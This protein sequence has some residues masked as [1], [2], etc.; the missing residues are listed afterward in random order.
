[1]ANTFITSDMVAP[2]ILMRV[3]NLLNMS[4]KFNRVY[5]DSI[6]GKYVGESIRIKKPLSFLT[7]DSEDITNHVQELKQK[8]ITM[9]I[10]TWVSVPFSVTNRELTMEL[11]EFDDTVIA[12]AVDRLVDRV[13]SDCCNLGKQIPNY[14]GTYASNVVATP[15]A[16]ND[17]IQTYRKLTEASVPRNNR[18]LILC[19][20]TFASLANAMHNV[21]AEQIAGKIIKGGLMI[22]M[23]GFQSIEED[24]QV[25]Y[26]TQAA[27]TTVT[28]NATLNKDSVLNQIALAGVDVDIAVGTA[29]E[30]DGV[31]AVNYVDKADTGVTRKFVVT[32]G[33]T[34]AGTKTVTFSPTIV[35]SDD[36]NNPQYQNVTAYPAAGSAVLFHGA[37]SGDTSS[38]WI[39]LAF[40]K[41]AFAMVCVPIEL[42]DEGPN[43]SR[44]HDKKAGLSINVTIGADILKYRKICRIDIFYGLKVLNEDLACRLLG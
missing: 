1:M 38:H 13:N 27:Q 12:P 17:V 24:Q 21:T 44:A 42:L 19:P 14:Y 33:S 35:M 28:V 4:N 34:G 37:P 40:H 20:E 10:D 18:H 43:C 29:F 6:V 25:K 5:E 2:R 23:S 32:A 9:N 41:N 16:F 11:N 30:I 3:K 39:N 15:D 31:N 7:V 22:P 26:L 36:N 8:Y